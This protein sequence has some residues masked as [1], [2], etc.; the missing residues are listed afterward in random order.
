MAGKDVCTACERR[1]GL[2]DGNRATR[3]DSRRRLRVHIAKRK[4]PGPPP[5]HTS[6][7]T[8]PRATVPLTALRT[9]RS[10]ARPA[11]F[12]NK[13]QRAADLDEEAR[14]AAALPEHEHQVRNDVT[15]KSGVPFVLGGGRVGKGKK[16]SD[17]RSTSLLAAAD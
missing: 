11:T 9:R 10:T 12:R 15:V 6:C 14:R 16:G 5:H 8:P 1:F 4:M 2:G 13:M 3:G 17:L 7:I